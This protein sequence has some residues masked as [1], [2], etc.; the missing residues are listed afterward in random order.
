MDAAN[1]HIYPAGFC[2]HQFSGIV[3][4]G[5]AFCRADTVGSPGA[6]SGFPDSEMRMEPRHKELQQRQFIKFRIPA[7]DSDLM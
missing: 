4:Y 2:D 5:R 7:H 1:R 6:G 3:P